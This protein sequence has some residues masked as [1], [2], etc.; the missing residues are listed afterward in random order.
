V[1]ARADAEVRARESR[2]HHGAPLAS[3]AGMDGETRRERLPAEAI[4]GLD[5]CIEL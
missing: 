3:A 5:R 4:R 1:H 2:L